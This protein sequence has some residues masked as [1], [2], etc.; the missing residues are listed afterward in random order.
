VLVALI[1]NRQLGVAR[2][3]EPLPYALAALAFVASRRVGVALRWAWIAA[4][5]VACLWLL[6]FVPRPLLAVLAGPLA[7]PGAWA[8]KQVA[9]IVERP[10]PRAVLALTGAVAGAIPALMGALDLYLCTHTP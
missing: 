10:S 2:F 9:W 6:V 7:L 3:W 5:V 8:G 4:G 1:S